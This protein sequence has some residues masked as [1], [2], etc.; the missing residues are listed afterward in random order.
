MEKT[1][2]IGNE[3]VRLTSN[4]TWAMIY[5]DQ[6]GR[7]IIPTIMPMLAAVADIISGLF[8]SAENPQKLEIS[9]VLKSLDG[10]SLIDAVVHL[11]SL[12]FV[13]LINITWAMAKAC[14]DSIPDP[15]T[16]VRGLDGFYVD[17]IAPEVFKL[18]CS[19]S[20]SSKNLK[21]LKGLADAVKTLQPSIST[22]SSSPE[23]NED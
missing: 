9:D 13:D 15:M 11:S 19:G 14:D 8:R 21:R 7:D 23:S 22:P 3:E 16:W 6:F 18:I 12:E 10:D 17:E 20:V 4:M 2:K 5:R 1:I